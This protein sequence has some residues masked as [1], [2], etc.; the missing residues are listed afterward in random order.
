MAQGVTYTNLTF[1]SYLT[2]NTVMSITNTKQL[3][4]PR[5]INK[6]VF[7]E[8]RRT[9]ADKMQSFLV[10]LLGFEWLKE[11]STV[12]PNV[13]KRITSFILNI[14]FVHPLSFLICCQYV[15]NLLLFLCP[16]KN[17]RVCSGTVGW[18]TALQPTRSWVQFPIQSLW[19]L[20][21]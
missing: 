9:Q 1:S 4:L 21:I 18:G 19:V 13:M 10:L 6:R 3:L 5:K 16:V 7:W 2:E 17:T 8:S 12:L 20:S 14:L 11:G 15:M